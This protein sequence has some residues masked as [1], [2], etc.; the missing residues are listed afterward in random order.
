MELVQR[1]RDLWVFASYVTSKD[2]FRA[3]AESRVISTETEWELADEFLQI[4]TINFGIPSIDLFAS[5]INN[6]CKVFVS[7]HQDPYS[8]AVDAFTLNWGEL[9]GFYAF[10]PFILVLRTIRKI[11]SDQAQGIVV[12]PYWPSQPWF[13]LFKE[14]LITS[15]LFL[16]PD[17]NMLSCP[18]R[19]THPFARKLI[20]V[21][22]ILSAKRLY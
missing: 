8:L 14:L 7:W 22:G 20:L 4:I 3:D 5:N 13:P 2:N 10:P 1:E 21:A 9:S 15:P 6:K 18:F 16:G 19:K 11:V 12:V 17:T